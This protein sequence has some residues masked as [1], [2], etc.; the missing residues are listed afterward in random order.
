M[1]TGIIEEIGRVSS[2]RAL[3]NGRIIDISCKHVL[4]RVEIGDSIAINGVCLTVID[5]TKNRFTAEAVE[6]TLKKSTLGKLQSG[7]AVNLEAALRADGKLGGH[8]V[9]GHVDFNS[10]VT[11]ISKLAESWLLSF[12][13]PQEYSRNVVLKGSISIDG[14]S[15]TIS[16]KKRNSFTVSVI[17]HT[18]EHTLFREYKIG[19]AVNMEVDLIGK[20]VLNYLEE[21]RGNTNVNES[22]LKNLGY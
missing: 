18:F 21:G 11:F 13:L 3:G 8:F 1:F 6:E 14:V 15:L 12:D 20:Y 7:S 17:P 22:F 16:E 5:F 2:I 9:Q 19:S 10:R 4:E